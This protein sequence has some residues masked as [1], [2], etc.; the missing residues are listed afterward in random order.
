[1]RKPLM[2]LV[3]LGLKLKLVR[4]WVRMSWLMKLKKPEMLNMRAVDLRPLAQVLW[5]SWV[6]DRPMSRVEEKDCPPNWVLGMMSCLVTLY[7]THLAAIFSRTL[8]GDSISWMSLKDE[9]L[10]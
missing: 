5:M 1:M 10:V 2:R 8:P 4:C 6:R 7:W 9:G 3:D